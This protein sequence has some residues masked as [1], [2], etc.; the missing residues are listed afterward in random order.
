MSSRIDWTQ[1]LEIPMEQYV[2]PERPPVS[3][4][5]YFGDRPSSG[6]PPCHPLP[7]QS[8]QDFLKTP[9]SS[10]IS[11]QESPLTRI[12]T[13]L[14]HSQSTHLSPRSTKTT[15]PSKNGPQRCLAIRTSRRRQKK[16]QLPIVRAWVNL[17]T[18][19]ARQ[20]FRTRRADNNSRYAEVDNSS[21]SSESVELDNSSQ[22]SESVELDNS[23]QSSEGDNN[24]ESQTFGHVKLK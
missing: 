2:M 19:R 22:S 4:L 11:S 24:S 15:P 10:N 20:K 1:V 21:Q 6:L 16:E 7:L 23:S 3:S 8:G 13:R 18:R 5:I 12:C 17:G 14:P 9:S